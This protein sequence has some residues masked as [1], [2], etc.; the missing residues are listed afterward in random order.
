MLI[1]A[2]CYDLLIVLLFS[3]GGSVDDTVCYCVLGLVIMY[4]VMMKNVH[5]FFYCDRHFRKYTGV[6]T[7][8]RAKINALVCFVRF[9]KR[10]RVRWNA[11]FR[12]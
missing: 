12:M 8:S 6:I 10:E 1:L 11:K 9:V 2:F 7:K 3:K 5:V 4:F